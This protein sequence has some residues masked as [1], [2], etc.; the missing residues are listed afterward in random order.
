MSNQRRKPRLAV[1]KLMS[2]RGYLVIA[3]HP[4]QADHKGVLVSDWASA[5][6]PEEAVLIGPITTREDWDEQCAI[7]RLK[8]LDEPAPDAVFHRC[9]FVDERMAF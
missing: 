1:E 4:G 9:L 7:A 8:P 5:S 3:L 2:K 6:F